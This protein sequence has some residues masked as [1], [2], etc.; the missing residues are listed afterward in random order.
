[1][2]NEDW[3]RI[4]KELNYNLKRIADVLEKHFSEGVKS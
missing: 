3:E 4:F 1:M 2:Q